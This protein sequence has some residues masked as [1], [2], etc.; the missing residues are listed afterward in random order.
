M[1]KKTLALVMA[2]VMTCMAGLS[3][4]G[5][6]ADAP[7]GETAAAGQ[8]NSGE[9]VELTVWAWDVALKQL[10]EAAVKYQETNPNVTFV[11]EEMGTDQIYAKLSTSLLTGDGLAD[12]I[13][14]EGEV[15]S[16]YAMNFP[17]GFLDLTDIVNEEDFLPIKV[18]EVK[19]NNKLH[20]YP[21]DAGPMAMFY[22]IDYFEQAGIKAEEIVTWD[23]LIE[24]SK[25]VS[26]TCKAPNGEPVKMIPMDPSG[27]NLVKAL[28]L[29]LGQGF[30]DADGKTIVD[31]PES[32]QAMEMVKRLYDEGATKDYTGWDQYEGVVANETVAAIPEAVWMIGTIKDKGPQTA[33]KWGVMDM[34]KFSADD[35]Y[36]S[37]NGGAILAINAK[38][39]APDAAKNFVQ[40]ALTDKQLQADGFIKYGLYPSYIP[41][42][43]NPAFGEPDEFFGGQKIYGTFIE[44][45]KNIPAV[46][47][48]ANYAETLDAFKAAVARVVLK[49]EDVTSTMQALQ[50]ELVSKYGQ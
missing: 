4:C 31:T 32:I 49:G 19:I 11:F 39:K 41:A 44:S 3:G 26:A 22:R 50:K 6:K 25:K 46:N 23:D 14:I 12:I 17:E 34:P 38:T 40:F 8:E 10:Q 1:K 33:G 27:A 20:G 24:A 5:K 42:Y 2:A 7:G 28:M 48:T 47:Y 16:G 18:G 15:L 30:F 45:G 21:W 9:K 37:T 36:T 13:Q 35:S 29:Q 43:D